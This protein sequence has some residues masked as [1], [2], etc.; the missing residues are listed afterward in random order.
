MGKDVAAASEPA[1]R[2]FERA[3][4]VLGFDLSQVCFEGPADRLN[5]TDVSQPAIFVASVAM[6]RALESGGIAADLSPQATAGLS[7]GEYAALHVAGWI[8]FEDCLKLVAER[9]RLMQAAAEATAGGMVSIIGLAEPDTV[10]LCT[11]AA[12]GAVLAPANF[13]CPGQIVVSGAKAACQRAVA[14]AEKFGAKAVPLVVAGAFHSSLMNSAATG[15]KAA[16]ASADIRNGRLGVVSNVSADYHAD[17]DGVRL[18]LEQQVTKPVRWQ[19]SIERLT[20]DGFDRFAEV[21]PGRVLTGLLRKI[22]RS[23]TALNFSDAAS[24]SRVPA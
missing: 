1:R 3:D 2:V 14:L 12:Q 20:R 11:E 8:D 24:L 23:R 21:G 18:L 4:A 6:W 17:P 15:L 13:N 7:L 16:L 10:K 5:A 9:G 22:D 19:A